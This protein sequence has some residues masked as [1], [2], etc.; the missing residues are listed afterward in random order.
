MTRNLLALGV[1]GGC[2][3]I[4]I[5]GAIVGA[6]APS[7]QAADAGAD[8]P[9]CDPD[10]GDPAGCAC[11]PGTFKQSDCYTGRPGTSGKGICQSGKRSCLSNGTQTACLGEVTP[12]PEICDYID[13]D[14]NGIVDDLPEIVDAA[15]IARCNSPACS[16]NNADAAITCW[17]PDP[18]ICGAGLKACAGGAKVGAPTG[19]NEF[20]HGGA[21]EV[22]NGIDDD[23]NGVIDD[24]L[25]QGG[26]CDMDDGSTWMADANPFE[27]GTPTQI[28]GECIHGQLACVDYGCTERSCADAGNQ[29]SPSQPAPETCDG[30]DNDCN[31]VVDDHACA[32]APVGNRFCCHSGSYYVCAPSSYTQYGFSCVDGG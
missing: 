24:G 9:V 4:G 19:C 15:V 13:N 6:C 26:P 12:Q 25:D 5:S 28:L 7:T 8:G 27:G 16:P 14:C 32:S 29:C 1:V 31:G 20:I 30:K 11:D 2:V 10:S 18:G 22:C 21:P 17:G 23:C 3:L